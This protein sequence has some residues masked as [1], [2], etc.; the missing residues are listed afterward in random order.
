MRRILNLVLILVLAALAAAPTAARTPNDVVGAYFD[1]VNAS[2]SAI[3]GHN[4]SNAQKK[5]TIRCDYSCIFSGFC[6]KYVNH[7]LTVKVGTEVEDLKTE[8]ED[9]GRLANDFNILLNTYV[10]LMRSMD[11]ARRQAAFLKDAAATTE[12]LQGNIDLLKRKLDTTV[13]RARDV[14]TRSLTLSDDISRGANIADAIVLAVG[15]SAEISAANWSDQIKADD[16]CYSLEWTQTDQI[17][18]WGASKQKALDS[19]TR[20]ARL[21]A[22]HM[23]GMLDKFSGHVFNIISSLQEPLRKLENGE[24]QAFWQRAALAGSI[25]NAVDDSPLHRYFAT[26]CDREAWCRAK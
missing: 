23:A 26:P 16:R 24:T 11:T 22:G 21:T 19:G 17:T 7:H 25:E 8:I 13:S 2:K 9:M 3:A 20:Q 1:A 5:F 18:T 10:D 4:R 14:Q 12:S 15:R 6:V